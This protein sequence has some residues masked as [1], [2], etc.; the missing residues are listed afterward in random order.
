MAKNIKAILFDIDD[1]LFDRNL[2]QIKVLQIIVD[3][4]PEVFSALDIKRVTEAF[5]E[6]DRLTLAE[7]NSGMPSEGLRDRRNRLFLRILG[8]PEHLVAKISEIYVRELPVC[9]TPVSGAVQLIRELS[10]KYQVGAVS[11][12]LPDVQYRK[13]E[14]L[15]LKNMLPCVVLSEEI[16]L[17]KPNP[18]IFLRA[19]L[20]LGRQPDECLFIGDSYT[21]DIVGAKN[22][23][24]QAC[25]FNRTK[26]QIQNGGIKPDFVVGDLSEIPKLLK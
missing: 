16:S 15:G 11:D 1:T 6:S 21:S 18:G 19:A 14:T 23:G 4:L 26:S 8:L 9:N 7:Y 12:G 2:A 24:M 17:R 25:W 3:S 22:A 13:L 20:L 10:R 5:L